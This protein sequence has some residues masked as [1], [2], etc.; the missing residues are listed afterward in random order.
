MTHGMWQG[1]GWSNPVADAVHGCL[2]L[3]VPWRAW[4]GCSLTAL[5]CSIFAYLFYLC[6][7]VLFGAIKYVDY[8]I[9]VF[10]FDYHDVNMAR[11]QD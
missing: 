7:F 2:Q 11:I 6:L 3:F 5:I 9:P 10:I 1:F 8:I 4:S